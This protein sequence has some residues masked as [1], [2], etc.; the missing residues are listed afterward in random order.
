MT[1][2]VIAAVVFIMLLAGCEN[3]SFHGS[4]GSGSGGKGGTGGSA[5]PQCRVLSIPM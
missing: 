4:G 2:N 5:G 1:V 3:C